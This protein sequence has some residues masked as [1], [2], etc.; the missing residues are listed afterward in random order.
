MK[1]N[2]CLLLIGLFI[3]KTQLFAQRVCA[4][5][6]VYQKQ[7]ITNPSFAQQQRDIESFTQ[8][9]IQQGGSQQTTNGLQRG[10]AVY[11]IPVVVHVVY[12][13]TAQNISDAQVL[14]QIDILNK[15]FQLNNADTSK[16]PL[17]FKS[18]LADCKIQFCLAKRDPNGAATTGIIR[19]STT[20]TSF[21]SNDGVKY[22]SSG[23]DN[24]WNSSQY[25]N[26]WVCNLSGGL[27][28]YAQF[29]GGAAATDGVVMLY[30]AFGNTGN[31]SA[32]YNLGRTATHEVG[33]WLNLR[34]IWGDANCGDDFVGDTPKQQTSNYSCPTYPRVTCSNGPNGD[35][36][37]N[38]MD[39]VDDQCM[40]MFSKGQRDRMYAILQTG[41]S[42]ASLAASLGCIAPTVTTCS[43]PTNI[44]ATSITQTG[45]TI[46]WTAATGASSYKVQYKLSTA[47]TY[48]TVT[49]TT[50]S[51]VLTG[52]TA[53]A[54]YNYNVATT[55][56]ATTSAYSALA[57]FTTATPTPTCIDVLETNNTLATAKAITAGTAFTA[58]IATSTD[59]DYYSFSNTTTAKNIQISLSTLPADYDVVLY[60]PSGT[61]VG[62]SQNA[63]TT[64]ENIKY[65]N[66]VIGTYKIY[67]Y[68]YGSTFSNTK[69]YTLLTQTSSTTFRTMYDADIAKPIV[70]LYPQPAM[71]IVNILFNENW[72]GSTTISVLNELGMLIKTEQI[73]VDANGSTKLNTATLKNGMYFIRIVNGKNI[74][75]QKL[76]I[77]H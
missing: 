50:T 62:I 2:L 19:K 12:N 58:Q 30:S 8:S 69:C 63:G 57:S 40:Q 42:R 52:L 38:Y 60:N 45:A 39:Y 26:I 61:Q 33:H 31:V 22:A 29:P 9:Y 3:F 64:S 14:S 25:L 15:D 70:S 11:N 43:T 24:A 20:T 13:T 66:G 59:V 36:F 34:H 35:M 74:S 47:T 21:G 49:A 23:G 54:T 28:G 53:G 68:G 56:A 5:H 10:A 77:Q 37:M 18:V 55:C 1:K 76:I 7:L 27:L 16:I 32:P 73:N 65:N 51:F 4:S 48:T 72:K 75:T 71:S 17:A 46:S 44:A 6:E 67:V 41:G